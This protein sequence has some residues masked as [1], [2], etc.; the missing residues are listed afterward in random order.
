MLCN[1]A[2]LVRLKAR[3][4]VTVKLR[5]QSCSVVLPYVPPVGNNRCL[6]GMFLRLQTRLRV[7]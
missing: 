2:A 6:L 3:T 4:P 1:V 7:A 5:V